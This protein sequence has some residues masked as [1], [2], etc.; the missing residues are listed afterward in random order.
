MEEQLVLHHTAEEDAPTY[1]SV[2]W[3]N[4][5][6]LSRHTNVIQLVTDR[7]GDGAGQIVK[8]ILELG[9]ARVGDLADAYELESGSKRDSGVDS[10]IHHGM[11]AVMANGTE[12]SSTRPTAQHVKTASEFHSILDTLLKS[13]ILVKVNTRTLMPLSD[14][15]EQLEESVISELF[16]DRKVTGPKKA[17]MFAD[18][19]G[20]LKRQWQADDSFSATRDYAPRS[21]MKRPGDYLEGPNKRVKTN[22]GLPNGYAINGEQSAGPTLS[23]LFR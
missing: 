19:V 18:A 3:P 4:A 22:G 21:A 13:G 12:K 2:N 17:R 1:Y 15:Q 10:T 23:V 6:N 16:P 20:K 5:Y 11:E 14:L 7:H 9:H 8:N